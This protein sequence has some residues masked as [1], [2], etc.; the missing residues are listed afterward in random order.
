MQKNVEFSILV[1]G[2]GGTGGYFLK[3]ISRYLSGG[4]HDKVYQIAVADGDIVEEH[5]LS[6]QCFIKEDIGNKKSSVL[7]ESL[8]AAFDLDLKCY[9]QYITSKAQL[10]EYLNLKDAN[11]IPVLIGC[12][13]NHGCRLICEELFKSLD[14]CFYFDSANEIESGEVVFSIKV[15]QK[16]ISPLRSDIFPDI[17]K[18]DIRNVTELSCEELNVI[19]PQHICTNMLAGNILLSAVCRLLEKNTYKAGFT[20]F[21]S[22]SMYMEFN[23][24]TCQ[25]EKY[26]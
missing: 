18:G 4:R 5:N 19:H 13:D 16:Q 17:L 24:V 22:A 12:V 21:N 1:I 6:R 25:K 14:T 20:S 9:P 8:N 10:E 7:V 26:E 11:V 15:N 3:E 2:A 23:K